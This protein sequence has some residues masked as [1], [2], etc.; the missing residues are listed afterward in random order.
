[1]NA[2]LAFVRPVMMHSG[3]LAEPLYSPAG[4]LAQMAVAELRRHPGVQRVCVLGFG[5]GAPLAMLAA[6]AVASDAFARVAPAA[7][8]VVH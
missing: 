2:D 7:V 8:D 5:R 6:R 4:A 3:I 1:M